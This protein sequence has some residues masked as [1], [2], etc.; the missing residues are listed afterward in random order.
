MGL[1]SLFIFNAPF[2]AITKNYYIYEINVIKTNLVEDQDHN[3]GLKT[4]KSCCQHFAECF[5]SH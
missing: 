5:T 1:A 4:D 3:F 2:E